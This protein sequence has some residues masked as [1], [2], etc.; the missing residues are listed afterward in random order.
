MEAMEPSS[1]LVGGMTRMILRLKGCVRCRGDLRFDEGAWQCLQCGQYYY[2]KAT[3]SIDSIRQAVREIGATPAGTAPITHYPGRRGAPQVVELAAAKPM[4]P[5][6]P[7]VAE[8]KA[9]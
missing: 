8:R 2:G 6:A 5:R 7:S 1:S 9:A 4:M 3:Q